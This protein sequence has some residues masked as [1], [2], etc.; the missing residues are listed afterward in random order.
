M[1]SIFRICTGEGWNEIPDAIAAQSTIFTA[2]LVRLY[3]CILLIICSIIG[4]SL[5]NSIFVDAMVSDNN[6][7]LEKQVKELTTK[8]DNLSKMINNNSQK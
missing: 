3:F 8:I 6:N 5:V 1:Y 2:R 7:A 4:L